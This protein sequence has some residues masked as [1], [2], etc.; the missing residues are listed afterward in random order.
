MTKTSILPRASACLSEAIWILLHCANLVQS[1]PKSISGNWPSLERWLSFSLQVSAAV[2]FSVGAKSSF[3]EDFSLMPG[4]T[5][6]NIHI[7]TVPSQATLLPPK[8]ICNDLEIYMLIL[9]KADY[10]K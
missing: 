10:E 9:S 1:H 3:S 7:S 5:C 6:I 8:T 2:H 4:I